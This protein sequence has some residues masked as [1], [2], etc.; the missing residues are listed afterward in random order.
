MLWSGVAHSHSQPPLETMQIL[1][2]PQNVSGHPR[3]RHR[4]LNFPLPLLSSPLLSRLVLKLSTSPPS[5]IFASLQTVGRRLAQSTA[6]K[7]RYPAVCPSLQLRLLS[8][9]L[10]CSSAR[11][12][13][14]DTFRAPCQSNFCCILLLKL[15]L[16]YVVLCLSL[17]IHNHR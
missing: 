8:P 16:H 1:S 13:A 4:R 17:Q 14:H 7:F 2:S 6:F 10:Y 9:I 11:I 12:V 3:L 5:P 15:S